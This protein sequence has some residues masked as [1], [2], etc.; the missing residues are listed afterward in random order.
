MGYLKNKHKRCKECEMRQALCICAFIPKIETKTKLIL[1]IHAAETKRTSNSGKLATKVLQN[2]EM[3][4]RGLKE[5]PIETEG[6]TVPERQSLLLFP[7][8]N[9]VDLTPEYVAQIKKPITLI[10]PDGNWRQASKV[11]NREP[12]LYSMP[13]VRVPVGRPSEYHL[14]LETRPEGLATFEAI[15]RA[16][17]VIEGKEVQEKMEDIFKIMVERTLWSRSKIKAADC[18]GGIPK[19]A[20]N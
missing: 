11:P 12:A 6:I 2:S 14:R 10:V 20:M 16:M 4:V 1:L 19:E 7:S 13:R 9:A 17:G 5:G 3:R 15:A 18:I 8:I